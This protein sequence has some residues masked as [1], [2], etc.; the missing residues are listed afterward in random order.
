MLQGSLQLTGVDH[1]HVKERERDI[2]GGD[3]EQRMAGTGLFDHGFQDIGEEQGHRG[4][5]RIPARGGR[6]GVRATVRVV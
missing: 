2:L 3:G 5:G 6:V 1:A 4:R